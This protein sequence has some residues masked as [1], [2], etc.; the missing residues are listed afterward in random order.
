[1]FRALKEIS[2]LSAYESQ[3]EFN[4]WQ[5]NQLEIERGIVRALKDIIGVERGYLGM[6]LDRRTQ[7][8]EAS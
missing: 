4:S 7:C 6:E 1:V 3:K 8:V 2:R 5:T